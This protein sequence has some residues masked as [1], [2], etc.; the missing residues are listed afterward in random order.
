MTDPE[1]RSYAESPPHVPDWSGD[2]Y[3][4]PDRNDH[5]VRLVREYI[6][7]RG[8]GMYVLRRGLGKSLVEAYYPIEVRAQFVGTLS[9]PQLAD[10]KEGR[11]VVVKELLRYDG[12]LTHQQLFEFKKNNRNSRRDL[13]RHA[14]ASYHKQDIDRSLEGEGDDHV[15]MLTEEVGEAFGDAVG[16]AMTPKINVPKTIS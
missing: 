9:G 16:Y 4:W 15:D 14:T 13:K 7:E 12:P 8:R 1:V 11:L 6:Q 10:Y 5:D 3:G 2:S